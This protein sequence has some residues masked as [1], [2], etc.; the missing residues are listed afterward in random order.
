MEH[1]ILNQQKGEMEQR[2]LPNF[3]FLTAQKI[4]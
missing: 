2:A 1:I 3:M 4:A